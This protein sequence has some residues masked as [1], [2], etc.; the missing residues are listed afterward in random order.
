MSH[1]SSSVPTGRVIFEIGGVPIREELARDSKIEIVKK[2]DLYSYI[3]SVLRQAASKL[4]TKMEFIN[5]STPPRLGNLVLHPQPLLEPPPVPE[6]VRTFSLQ[7][8]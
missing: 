6:T 7:A 1:K 8:P 2:L 5:K 3:S 4:P